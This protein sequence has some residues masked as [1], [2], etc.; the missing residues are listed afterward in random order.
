[1]TKCIS[2]H[3]TPRLSNLDGPTL[4]L[5][6][7]DSAI[8][9]MRRSQ[10]L[11]MNT[12]CPPL[13]SKKNQSLHLRVMGLECLNFERA[14]NHLQLNLLELQLKKKKRAIRLIP[15]WEMII[16][17]KKNQ[18][19]QFS[20]IS[21]VM[22]MVAQVKMKYNMSSPVFPNHKLHITMILKSSIDINIFKYFL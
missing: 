21:L 6:V 15:F 5:E 11:T 12:S 2:I 19:I 16:F 8:K 1:M 3:L 17:L 13:S 9:L 18:E 4:R 14:R 7:I 20:L 10:R 22:E